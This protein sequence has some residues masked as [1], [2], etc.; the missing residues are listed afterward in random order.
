MKKTTTYP[1]STTSPSLPAELERARRRLQTAQRDFHL[2][3]Q[4]V[5]M[6]RARKDDF[7]GW[8]VAEYAYEH[9]RDT[10]YAAMSWLWD[11]QQRTQPRTWLWLGELVP[12]TVA[13]TP[14][15]LDAIFHPP[16]MT[17]RRKEAA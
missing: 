13:I 11:V 16:S 7:A 9:H 8:Q 2:A 3:R 10:L 12:N 5:R 17:A 14:G 15:E 4:V 1:T 6:H